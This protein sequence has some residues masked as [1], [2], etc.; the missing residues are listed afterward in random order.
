MFIVFILDTPDKT[1]LMDHSSIK[2]IQ[3]IHLYVLAN[4]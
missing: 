3:L 1:I 2:V 4:L